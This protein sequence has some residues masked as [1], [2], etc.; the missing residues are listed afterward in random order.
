[1]SKHDVIMAHT[2]QKHVKVSKAPGIIRFAAIL[3]KQTFL[4]SKICV[5]L[6]HI[7]HITY[8]QNCCS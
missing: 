4:E 7:T 8:S 1:M 6:K 3:K 5:V 2:L